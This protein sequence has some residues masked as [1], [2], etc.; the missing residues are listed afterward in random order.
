MPVQFAIVT[1][2]LTEV[3]VNTA[4]EQSERLDKYLFEDRAR[5]EQMQSKHTWLLKALI[6][7]VCALAIVFLFTML[8]FES[9]EANSQESQEGFYVEFSKMPTQTFRNEKTGVYRAVFKATR[10][11]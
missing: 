6:S 3:Q 9:G 1:A 5:F 4:R 2:F 11:P 7:S 8:R 10:I